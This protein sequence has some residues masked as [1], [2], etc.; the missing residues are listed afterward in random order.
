MKAE[1]VYHN[2]T[3][4]TG[5]VLEE[6]TEQACKLKQLVHDVFKQFPDKKT[7]FEVAVILLKNGYR[8]PVWS[9]RARINALTKKTYLVKSTTAEAMGNYNR[10]NHTWKLSVHPDNSIPALIKFKNR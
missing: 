5:E 6:A 4:L 7:P 3:N 10:P 8:Y 2:T 1:K 9:I